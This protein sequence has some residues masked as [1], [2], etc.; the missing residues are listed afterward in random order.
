MN[1]TV[2][3]FGREVLSI[4]TDEAAGD[5]DAA[6]CV[7]SAVAFGFVEACRY[8]VVPGGET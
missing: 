6:D 3:L 7:T 4:S 2:R 5:D 1:L 8:D